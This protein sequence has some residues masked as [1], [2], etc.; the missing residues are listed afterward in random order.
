M[1][2]LFLV[3]E[4]GDDV[5]R[6]WPKDAKCSAPEIELSVGTVHVAS[7]AFQAIGMTNEQMASV[8]QC[9]HQPFDSRPCALLPP[10]PAEGQVRR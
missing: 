8:S 1:Y 4:T 6:T 3:S 7:F 5:G 10:L 9:A 2:C